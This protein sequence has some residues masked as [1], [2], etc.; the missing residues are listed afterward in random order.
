[1]GRTSVSVAF[2]CAAAT[3]HPDLWLSTSLVVEARTHHTDA[4]L[5]EHRGLVGL[6]HS[7]GGQ[8]PE[9]EHR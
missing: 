3:L 1:M 6:R 4:T 5:A 7:P 8:L 9:R 2:S